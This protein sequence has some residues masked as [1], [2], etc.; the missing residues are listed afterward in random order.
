[1][2][3]AGRNQ[4][5]LPGCVSCESLNTWRGGIGVGWYGPR[6]YLLGDPIRLLLQRIVAGPNGKLSL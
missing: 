6:H 4:I 5:S 1:M 3:Y 2:V